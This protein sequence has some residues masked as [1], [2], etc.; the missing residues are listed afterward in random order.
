MPRPAVDPIEADEAYDLRDLG[1]LVAWGASAALAVSIAVLAAR[2]D[3]G[4]RR[5][6]DAFN[7][8]F[9]QRPAV[10]GAPA[11][12]R[13]GSGEPEQ[14]RV[15]E[16][17]ARLAGDRD[18]LL[19][20]L[21]AVERSLEVTGSVTAQPRPAASESASIK[22]TPPA[23]MAPPA[24]TPEPAAAASPTVTAAVGPTSAA[25][26]SDRID[27]RAAPGPAPAQQVP[28]L[29]P[30]ALDPVADSSVTRSEFGIDLG[31][32]GSIDGL[33]AMWNT[34]RAQHGALLEALRPTVAVRE[35]GRAGG[36]ELR[37]VVGP[38][39]NAATAARLCAVIASTGRAC[40]PSGFDGPR[41]TL[42]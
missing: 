39:A 42:R 41:L 36:V 31:A 21:D 34:V 14:R 30:G 38:V 24:A 32:D 18:R 8:H 17:L 40:Q 3:V 16:Q 20:R 1:R 23:P 13:D 29:L 7:G 15:A 33:R 25:A 37:L 4:A 22:I 26:K 5:L 28:P 35:S 6:Q 9:G 12:V 27:G 11:P 19:A 2:S 10:A